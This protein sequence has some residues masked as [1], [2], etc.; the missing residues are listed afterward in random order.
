MRQHASATE[1]SLFD[2][3]SPAALE[4]LEER[5]LER[6]A[7]QIDGLWNGFGVQPRRIPGNA[8]PVLDVVGTD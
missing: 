5:E 3:D 7:L 1:L 6:R 4:R 8:A 2:T